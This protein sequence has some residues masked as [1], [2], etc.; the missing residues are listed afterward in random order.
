MVRDG[1]LSQRTDTALELD[2]R[3]DSMVRVRER[4]AGSWIDDF[5]VGDAWWESTLRAWRSELI[6]LLVRTG[7]AKSWVRYR[8]FFIAISFYFTTVKS[9]FLTTSSLYPPFAG[10]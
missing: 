7:F 2:R 4:L 3:R 10:L 5:R 6:D 8:Y 1:F 9:L